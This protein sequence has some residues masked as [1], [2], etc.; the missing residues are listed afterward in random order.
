MMRKRVTAPKGRSRSKTPARKKKAMNYHTPVGTQRTGLGNR[1]RMK[2]IYSDFFVLNP[3]LGGVVD[4]YQ[5]RLNS[6]F[7]PNF[8]QIGHQP[9]AHD[10]MEPL[11]E[12]YVVTDCSY[13]VKMNNVD[14]NSTV[15]CG[16][17]V[18]DS[19]NTT[20]NATLIIEQGNV[21]WQLLGDIGSGHDIVEFSGSV[22]L[23][24]LMGKARSNYIDGSQYNAAFGSNPADVGFL[25]IWGGASDQASDLSSFRCWIELTY[26][27][28]L[29][30]SKLVAQS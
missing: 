27:V 22:D 1:Q 10:Q 14:G 16:V 29:K 17:Y 5:F 24:K 25:T 18:S 9:S 11:F 21:D 15:V 7:D 26:T 2:M 23:P 28:I 19:V 8:T 13:K 3:G 4:N 6:I 20:A 30:G 12:Q